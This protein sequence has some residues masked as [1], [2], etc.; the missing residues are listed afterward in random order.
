MIEISQSELATWAR[1]PR[2][3]YASYYLG[4]VPTE[5]PVCSSR[6]LGTRVHTALEA[7]QG[8]DMDPIVV[9]TVIY[10]MLLD[11]HPEVSQDILKE[12]ELATIM[13]SGYTEWLAAEG[14][15]A[16]LETVA[17]EAEVKVPM[18]GLDGVLLRARLD[19]VV[20]DSD[21]FSMFKDY[22]T[23][24]SFERHE[25]LDMDFQMKIYCLITRLLRAAGA[26]EAPDVR[27]GILDTLRRVK[28][29][30]RSQPPYYRRD[31]FSY[32]DDVM[33]STARRAGKLCTEI[34][35]ARAVLDAAAARGADLAEV[36]LIQQTELRP[37]P[38]LKE[39]S[40]S[41]PLAG[42]V[43]TAMDDGSDW[44]GILTQSGRFRQSDPYEY[45]R[46]D[47]LKAIREALAR[48]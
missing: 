45:Y 22:K 23:A 34:L 33:V 14:L 21:G 8:Y 6:E 25:I 38:L 1:C 44:P 2:K 35:H 24:D 42:G 20:R 48:V 41:C 9:L 36:N 16:H 4:C 18:P 31:T 43:C 12:R 40:W 28:R 29:S 3:W 11:E 5:E 30:S 26:P 13:V 15:D 7:A 46:A 37:V 32:N 39:C 17:T 10:Q 19:A 47:P 27:G